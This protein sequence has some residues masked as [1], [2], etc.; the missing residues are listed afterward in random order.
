MNKT[1]KNSFEDLQDRIQHRFKQNIFI[2]TTLNL[3]IKIATFALWIYFAATLPPSEI[4]KYTLSNSYIEILSS[5]FLMELSPCIFRFY[6]DKKNHLV[7]LSNIIFIFIISLI[8]LTIGYIFLFKELVLVSPGISEIVNSNTNYVFI[9]F[10][11]A[12]NMIM[13][14]SLSHFAALGMTSNYTRILI[15]NNILFISVSLIAIQLG[16]GFSGLLFSRMVSL[17]VPLGF[18]IQP[19][20]R[21]LSMNLIS[22]PILKELLSYSCPLIIAVTIGVFSSNLGRLL[23][24]KYTNLTTLGVYGF[25]FMIATNIHMLWHSFNQAWTPKIF[26]ELTHNENDKSIDKLTFIILRFSFCY[27][28]IVF[29]SII[30]GKLFVFELVLKKAYLE[31]VYILYILVIGAFFGGISVIISPY[32]YHTKKTAFISY[33]AILGSLLN[34]FTTFFLVKSFE[35]DGAALAML[36]T[37][38]LGPLILIFLFRNEIKRITII[39][40]WLFLF[41]LIF[42]LGSLSLIIY[43]FDHIFLSFILIAV[44]ISYQN[45]EVSTMLE[46]FFYKGIKYIKKYC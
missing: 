4:G 11:I 6:H 10:I 29:I 46:P 9:L 3:L 26:F 14:L 1:K 44:L 42:L 16:Y 34:I 28:C 5:I 8:L 13:N 22:Y 17:L 2:Y 31:S 27:L 40:R 24:D 35:Q 36:I 19:E 20:L 45:G 30:L 21:G 33:A 39:L 41:S 32:I 43:K 18:F 15:F 38:I 37:N 23:L 12:F 7:M 25:F